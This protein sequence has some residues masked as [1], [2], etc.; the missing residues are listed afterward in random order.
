MTFVPKAV[1]KKLYTHSSLRN[2]DGGVRFAVKN[3]LAPATLRTIRHIQINGQPV[4]ED[5]IKVARDNGPPVLLN[6]INP[7]QPLDFPLGTLLTL[8]LKHISE[9][10]RQ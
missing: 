10:T 7:E 6:Q 9:P 8:S 3:R 5:H 2:E 4:P 1:L